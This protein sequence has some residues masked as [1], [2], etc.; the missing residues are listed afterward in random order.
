M[1]IHVGLPVSCAQPLVWRVIGKNLRS[2]G[3][4]GYVGEVEGLHFMRLGARG[5]I[6]MSM[7]VGSNHPVQGR[8]EVLERI[9]RNSIGGP[10]GGGG[11]RAGRHRKKGEAARGERGAG[12]GKTTQL[13]VRGWLGEKETRT[14]AQMRTT[15]R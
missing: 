12:T 15:A 4:V 3:D 7:E 11:S 9:V 6:L 2:K 10:T 14:T 1:E 13:E 5:Q 8:R